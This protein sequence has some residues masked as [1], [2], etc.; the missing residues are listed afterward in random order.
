VPNQDTPTYVYR[1]A[2][3]GEFVDEAYALEH[4]DTT[5]REEVT[6]R[7][8]A[9]IADDG[10]MFEVPGDRLREL[11][12]QAA[13]G[14][15]LEDRV[16][17]LELELSRARLP[18]ESDPGDKLAELLIGQGY[19]ATYGA[20]IAALRDLG[21]FPLE[22]YDAVIRYTEQRINALKL[23]TDPQ[24]AEAARAQDRELE[25]IR[26]GR[27]LRNDLKAVAERL[28]ARDRLEGRG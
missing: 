6:D 17:E 1:D 27:R 24:A 23:S 16:A 11:R 12:D 28:Q 25:L 5:E 26:C 7:T 2:S 22:A 8:R 4:P 18:V 14:A 20:L 13:A 21:S 19:A 3:T 10:G 15:G 9:Q